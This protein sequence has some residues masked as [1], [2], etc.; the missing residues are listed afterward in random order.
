[1]CFEVSVF[2]DF[3]VVLWVRM[4]FMIVAFPDI[5][6]MKTGY[7]LTEEKRARCFEQCAFGRTWTSACIPGGQ[8]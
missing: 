8:T 4:W 5:T 2:F 1:M 7:H 6:L 3:I